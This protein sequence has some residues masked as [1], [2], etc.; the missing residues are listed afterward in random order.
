MPTKKFSELEADPNTVL[1]S[2]EPTDL[3]LAY[4]QS[5]ALD[6]RKVKVIQFQNAVQ[7]VV[8]LSDIVVYTANG[9][10]TKADYLNLAGILV[11]AIGGG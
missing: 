10:W 5:E 8:T 1:S 2:L 6:A 3:L 9:T 7:E 11:R 4:D